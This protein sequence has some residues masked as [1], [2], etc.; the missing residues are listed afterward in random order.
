MDEM[1]Y[2]AMTG[3]KQTEYAQAINSNNLANISTNGF[4]ADLHSFSS[5]PING[6]GVDSR[7]NA[8]VESYGTDFSQGP[9]ANTGRDLDVAINGRG[10]LAV[11]APDGSE[12]YTRAG[13]LRV[14]SGGLLTNGA[15]HLVLGDGGPLAVPPNSSLTIGKDGTVTVQPLGQGPEALVIVDRLKLVNPDIK[16]LAKGSDG[17]LHLPAGESADADAAVTITAGALEQSNVNVA[18]TLVNMIELSRQYE[19]QVNVMKTA[20]ENADAAAK[21]MNVG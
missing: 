16:M 6:P 8:V 19:M 18:M 7:V 21:L 13:D 11:Q 2:L 10:F 9:V 12:A 20:K 5:E 15:G 14:N 4:R 17:L 3:A 1:V